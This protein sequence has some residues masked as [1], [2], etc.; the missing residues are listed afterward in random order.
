[1]TDRI[2]HP[3][4]EV[5]IVVGNYPHTL[6]LKDGRIQSSGVKLNFIEYSPVRKA[7]APMVN[8]RSFDICELAIGTFFQARDAGIPL[9]LLP[10][11]MVGAFRHSNLW[12]DPSKGILTPEGLKGRR[13]GVR[14]YTQ[15]TGLWVRGILQEQYGVPSDEVTWVTTEDSHVAGFSNP[16]NVEIVSTGAGLEDMLHNGKIAA[17]IMGPEQGDKTLRQVI[18]DA[19]AA[20]AQWYAKHHIVPINHMVVV[21]EDLLQRDPAAIHEIYDMFRRGYEMTLPTI[22]DTAPSGICI[23]LENVW[24]AVQ[25]AMRYAVQ[26]K[27]ITHVFDKKEIFPEIIQTIGV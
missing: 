21:T 23:G 11:V 2:M 18:P 7:F 27:L 15:T 8:E 19:D 26:Q 1:M 6:P 3:T 24:N 5:S 4:Q 14:A 13:V 17:V 10:V 9:R 12:Y 16:P 25:V 22:V 20:A